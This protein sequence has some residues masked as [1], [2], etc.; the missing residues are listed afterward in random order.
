MSE[1]KKDVEVTIEQTIEE[2]EEMAAPGIA[3]NHNETLVRD[4]EDEDEKM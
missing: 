2:L 1:N 4:Q 3:L